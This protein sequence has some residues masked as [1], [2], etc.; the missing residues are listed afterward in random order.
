MSEWI[1]QIAG[2]L[3]LV[4][5]VLQMLPGTKYVQYVKL[6]TGLLLILIV[7]RP[8]LKIGEADVYLEQKIQEFVKNQE[9][10]EEEI[11]V[12]GEMFRMESEELKVMEQE[13]VSIEEIEQVQVEV[14]IG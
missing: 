9:R 11:A 3:L 7:L 1:K 8:V 2:Y 12:S 4:S 5:V 6:F 13:V 14:A 10:L